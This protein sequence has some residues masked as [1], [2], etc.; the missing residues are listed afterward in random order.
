MKFGQLK[1]GAA[2][3]FDGETYVKTSPM[4]GRTLDKGTQKF[5]RRAVEVNRSDEAEPAKPSKQNRSVTQAEVTEA[6]ADFY[7]HCEQCLQELTPQLD[8]KLLERLCMQLENA[9]Q[10]FLAK[11]N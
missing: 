9:K 10:D 11:I 5:F 8:M 3:E 7:R 4:I 2:F 1:I 6:F